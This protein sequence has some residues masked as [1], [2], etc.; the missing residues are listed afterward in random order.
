MW[1]Q[2]MNLVNLFIGF[3]GRI[4]RAKFWI[5]V[6]CVLAVLFVA[7][8]VTAAVSSSID[9]ALGTVRIASIPLAYVGAVNG[10]KRL[11]DR[12]KSGW[13][14]CLFSAPP[15][16][17]FV[18]G[19]LGIG[20]SPDSSVVTSVVQLILFAIMLW[21]LVELGCLR[22]TI[23]QNKYGRDPLAPEIL[24]PPVRTHA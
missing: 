19:A 14:V 18:A 11:H 1:E 4:N 5:V 3:N 15:V 13:W 20:T 21:G 22:G 16:L 6:L 10:I 23:G 24:T 2:A 17:L 9:S 7:G 12:N 8:G